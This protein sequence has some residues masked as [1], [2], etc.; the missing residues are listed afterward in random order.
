[1][2]EKI[3]TWLLAQLAQH[4]EATM[5]LVCVAGGLFAHHKGLI[6]ISLRRKAGQPPDP[7]SGRRSALLR[8]REGV[9]EHDI[10]MPDNWPDSDG[11]KI[12]LT[13]HID[14]RAR[15][16]VDQALQKT[17][18]PEIDSAKFRLGILEPE[19]AAVKRELRETHDTVIRLDARLDGVKED[20]REVKEAMGQINETISENAKRTHQLLGT[21][22]EKGRA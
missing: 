13:P 12:G 2:A 22:L 8:W 16:L 18:I 6:T 11:L 1:M 7:I 20:L 15:R 9:Q 5:I 14:E 3:V 17:V 21:L 19:V 4:P 10:S